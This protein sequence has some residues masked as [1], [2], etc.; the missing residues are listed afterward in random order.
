MNIS[1]EPTF[2]IP[3]VWIKEDIIVEFDEQGESKLTEPSILIFIGFNL[4]TL[5]SINVVG[6][7]DS[8][9][10]YLTANLSSRTFKASLID[11]LTNLSDQHY[12]WKQNRF[13][14]NFFYI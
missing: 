2:A 10:E 14:Y 6:F 11:F 8:K 7:N 3:P 9:V 5:I 4:P 1:K 12:Q 13:A